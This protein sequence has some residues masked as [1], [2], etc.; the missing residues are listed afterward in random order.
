MRMHVDRLFLLLMAATVIAGCSAYRANYDI[1]LV[2][3]VRPESAEA[4]Y[5]KHDI[6]K[7][8]ENGP[9]QSFFEDGLVKIVWTPTASEVAFELTNRTSRPIKI[10]WEDAKFVDKAGSA[11]RIIHSTVDYAKAGEVQEATVVEGNASLADAL[12][13]VDNVFYSDMRWQRKPMFQ[14]FAMSRK[15]EHFEDDVQKHVGEKFDVTLPLE[16]GGTVHVYSFT[17]EVTNVEVTK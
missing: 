12:F 15:A 14:T 8:E 16:I 7:V 3:A 6:I 9:D 13:P 4:Q 2:K 17:F 1:G 11:R 5:G 10:N